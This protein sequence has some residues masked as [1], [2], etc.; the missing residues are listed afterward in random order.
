MIRK[1]I[2]RILTLTLIIQLLPLG[3][4]LNQTASAAPDFSSTYLPELKS[5][6]ATIATVIRNEKAF[7]QD[8]KFESKE[9]IFDFTVR[10]HRNTLSGL[11]II[12][13][14]PSKPTSGLA[15]P[16]ETF[17][18]SVFSGALRYGSDYFSAFSWSQLNGLQSRV[19]DGDFFLETYQLKGD[20]DWTFAEN[21]NEGMGFCEGNYFLSQINIW[22]QAKRT[23]DLYLPGSTNALTYCKSNITTCE[24]GV[25]GTD[26]WKRNNLKN[27]L[28]P[29]IREFDYQDFV[30]YSNCYKGDWS[31][32][33]FS[34]SKS[35][36]PTSG[37]LEIVDFKAQYE[38]V[39]KE[40]TSMEAQLK[41]LTSERDALTSQATS[42]RNQVSTLTSEKSSLQSQVST[43][44]S[45]KSSLQSQ[46]STLTS[47]KSSLQSQVN[48]LRSTLD[49]SQK[50]LL[51]MCKA[52]P[53]PKGC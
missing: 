38:N 29:A 3:I 44:T 11:S 51:V 52:K 2:G 10:V 39:M 28:C 16:C 17:E 7:G 40:K 30:Y 53:K 6:K 48:S 27:A 50:K 45:E 18:G 9:F 32:M 36:A 42:L 5:F 1:N 13:Q 37:K 34:I 4:Q 21:R 19:Q 47:E 12:I 41:T 24:N 20:M 49:I 23:I 25:S 14:G 43:L 33:N 22:D 31:S 26:F 15:A 8:F 46:V 35:N